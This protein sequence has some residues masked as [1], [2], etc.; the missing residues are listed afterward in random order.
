M[1]F[2]G[3]LGR[4]GETHR[5]WWHVWE[6]W[7]SQREGELVEIIDNLVAKPSDW[8]TD[9]RQGTENGTKGFP[10]PIPKQ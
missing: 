9:R 10:V 3:H 2:G 8:E 5:W 6:E 4:D 7:R 1:L